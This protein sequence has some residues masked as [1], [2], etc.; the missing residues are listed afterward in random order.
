MDRFGRHDADD[1]QMMAAANLA[2]NLALPTEAAGEKHLSVPEREITWFRRLY[3]KAVAGFYDV[4]L[5]GSGW[6]IY[7]GREWT[8]V[9][10]AGL[11]GSIKFSRQC[12][13]I[14]L[15]TTGIL[16]DAPFSTRNSIRF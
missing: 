16:F 10:R 8:G 3:E 6:C 5:A 15:W 4:V 2:F 1:L 7:A 13:L 14:S 11:R 9:S 12:R